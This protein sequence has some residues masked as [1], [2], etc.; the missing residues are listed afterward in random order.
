MKYVAHKNDGKGLIQSPVILIAE[1]L[2]KT[3]EELIAEIPEGLNPIIVSE[4]D[5]PTREYARSWQIQN[6]VL[7]VNMVSA[8]D[9]FRNRLRGFRASKLA[10][11][12]VEFQRALETGADTTDIVARKQY[13]RDITDLPAIDT[14]DS[15]DALDALWAE[16][17]A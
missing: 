5:L 13:W 6:G 8:R 7:S 10:E 15:T 17:T 4:E 11:L 16:I 14:A 12:D 2:D 9:A 3:L 1:P